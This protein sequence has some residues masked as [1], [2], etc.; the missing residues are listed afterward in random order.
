MAGLKNNLSIDGV[1]GYTKQMNFIENYT[2]MGWYHTEGYFP[3]MQILSTSLRRNIP[4]LEKLPT[5]KFMLQ[6]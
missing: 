6:P 1:T 4:N 5:F 3:N 2:F